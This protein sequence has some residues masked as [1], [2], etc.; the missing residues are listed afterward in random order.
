MKDIKDINRDIL[1]IKTVLS[2]KTNSTDT[3]RV[4]KEFKNY[5]S[6]SDLKDLYNKVMPPL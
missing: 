2:T 1:G 5:S 4:W 3:E 6:Y